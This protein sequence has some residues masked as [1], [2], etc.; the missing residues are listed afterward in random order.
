MIASGRIRGFV[1][2]AVEKAF[3]KANDLTDRPQSMKA[4]ETNVGW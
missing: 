2:G 3:E 4:V 1:G